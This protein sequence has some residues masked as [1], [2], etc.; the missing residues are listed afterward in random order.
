MIYHS[1][2]GKLFCFGKIPIPVEISS[3][4]TFCTLPAIFSKALLQHLNVFKVKKCFYYKICKI[5]L[6]LNKN[7]K[8]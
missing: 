1:M 8:E 7:N 2:V 4:L 5:P 3:N 6:F